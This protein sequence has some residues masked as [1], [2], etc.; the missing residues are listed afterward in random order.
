MKQGDI[1]L[2]D[3]SPSTGSELRG[4]H[5][6]LIVQSSFINKTAIQTTVVVGISSNL[7]LQ[8]IPGNILLKKGSIGLKK[9]SVVN[10]SQM[11]TIDKSRLQKRI[12][13][14]NQDQLTQ[15]FWGIDRLFGR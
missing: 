8:K 9:D 4:P 1:Y 6:A 15:V 13:G 7:N 5:P 2:L 10:V 12:G 14:I 3:F 11:Y